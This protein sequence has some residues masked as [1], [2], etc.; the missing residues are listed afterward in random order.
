MITSA[1]LA[2]PNLAEVFEH[3]LTWQEWW[4]EFDANACCPDAVTAARTFCG[5]RGSA[6]V[7]SGISRLLTGD[8]A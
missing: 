2:Q 5:C 7:P 1:D 4:D 6:Q 8:P 3:A